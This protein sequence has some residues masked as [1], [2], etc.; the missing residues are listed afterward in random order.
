MNGVSVATA[1][2]RQWHAYELSLVREYGCTVL[3]KKKRCCKSF[4]AYEMLECMRSITDSDP[5]D[6][7][8]KF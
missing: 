6:C 5:I 2:D 4:S 1:R 7:L 3:S 8:L